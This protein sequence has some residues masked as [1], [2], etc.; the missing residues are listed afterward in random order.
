MVE[1]E[2]PGLFAAPA[3]LGDERAALAIARHHL[4][5]NCARHVTLVRA[6][7]RCARSPG[8]AQLPS[9]DP[10]EQRIER[11]IQHLGQ[12]SRRH[13]VPKQRLRPQELFMRLRAH[14]Q[15]EREPLRRERCHLRRAGLGRWPRH[16]QR[17]LLRHPL[18]P[19]RDIP[20]WRPPRQHD[21]DR[22][23]A[24]AARLSHQ[25]LG[26]LVR[27]VR[28]QQHHPAQVETPVFQRRGDHGKPPRRPRRPDPLERPVLRHAEHPRAVDEHRWARRR[29]IELSRLHLAEVHQH[30]R[31][32]PPLLSQ[33]LLEPL[34][35]LSIRHR[36]EA[37]HFHPS[38]L[39]R[40]FD[41]P[42]RRNQRLSR[43][44]S[45]A[46]PRVSPPRPQTPPSRRHS[47]TRS[48]PRQRWAIRPTDLS[49]V[50]HSFF[51]ILCND[52]GSS[53]PLFISPTVDCQTLLV[54]WL[55]D[56]WWRWATECK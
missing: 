32:E 26:A 35:H 39:S 19:L 16:H 33:K 24:L 15:L 2:E 43:R 3:V 47:D 27:E 52:L 14:R 28:R 17:R 48:R 45:R 56:R 34:H 54:R 5:P 51:V 46:A 6:R 13:L 22:G 10:I 40:T 25:V 11:A 55:L 44:R 41:A 7:L 37:N 50:A 20:P 1:L 30:R 9:F 12:I 36:L 8:L 4:P 42:R 31:G 38:S 29:Q 21:R 53:L 18:E 49:N 23:L